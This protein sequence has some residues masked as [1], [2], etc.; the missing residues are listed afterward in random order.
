M[1]TNWR[2][3]F[4]RLWPLIDGTGDNYVGGP[5][6][7]A[8]IQAVGPDFPVYPKLMASRCVRNPVHGSVRVGPVD[9]IDDEHVNG[10]LAAPG[11]RNYV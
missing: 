7:V 10:C 4:N 5:R 11:V 6:F 8:K 3:L 9:V 1:P 2:A